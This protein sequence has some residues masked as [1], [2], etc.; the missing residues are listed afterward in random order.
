MDDELRKYFSKIGRLGGKANKG[1]ASEKCR[2]AAQVR[3][4]KEKA[5]KK[6]LQDDED[7]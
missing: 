5:K 1:K 4:Q 7:E 2:R 3:W 6:H